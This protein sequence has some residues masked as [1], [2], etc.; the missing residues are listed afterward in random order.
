MGVMPDSPLAKALLALA[1]VLGSV[2]AFLLG[3]AARSGADRATIRSLHN[4]V[5]ELK[6]ARLEHGA[7]LAAHT[8]MHDGYVRT[9]S[10]MSATMAKVSDDCAY[11]RGRVDSI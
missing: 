3:K 8:A 7:T 1:P 4:D 5:K 6:A 9:M 10:A 11:I 2:I